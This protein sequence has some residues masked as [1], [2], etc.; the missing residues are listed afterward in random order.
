MNKIKIGARGSLLSK[1]Y[2]KKVKELILKNCHVLEKDIFLKE[3]KT[4]GDIFK[5]K[6]YQKLVEKNY[7]AKRLRKNY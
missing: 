6:N 5:E 1:A 4:S 2:V 3:I 7:F